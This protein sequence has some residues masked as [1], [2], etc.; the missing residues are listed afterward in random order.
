MEKQCKIRQGSTLRAAKERLKPASLPKGKK[1]FE[2]L[3][4]SEKTLKYFGSN[5]VQPINLKN[6][7]PAGIL[8]E[9]LLKWTELM[10]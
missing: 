7:V 10:G 4:R 8:I 9:I 6:T 2:T 5:D 3:A 1:G